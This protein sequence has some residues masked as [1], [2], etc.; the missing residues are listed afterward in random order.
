MVLLQQ[1][2]T[3]TMIN[4]VAHWLQLQILLTKMAIDRL[5]LLLAIQLLIGDDGMQLQRISKIWLQRSC[6]CTVCG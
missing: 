2:T 5:L 4:A 1:K 3:T 6:M